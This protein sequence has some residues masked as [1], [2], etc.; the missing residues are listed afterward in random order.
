MW[1]RQTPRN[2]PRRW[3]STWE[4]QIAIQGESGP[5][6]I[7]NLAGRRAWVL[8]TS[9]GPP[10]KRCTT[11]FVRPSA[12]R[13]SVGLRPSAIHY[14]G[15]GG[16]PEKP[17]LEAGRRSRRDRSPFAI[18]GA[19]AHHFGTFRLRAILLASGLSLH[20]TSTNR[21]SSAARRVRQSRQRPSHAAS[22]LINKP[23]LPQSSSPV[24]REV[25]KL[26]LVKRQMYGRGKLDLL[27]AR[28]IGAA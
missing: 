19:R 6:R 17:P 26:K 22:L 7:R 9:G 16:A 25:T 20:R 18:Q 2:A 12:P 21:G 23:L 5:R 14:S 4:L 15:S 24:Q 11:V 1:R 28:V 27:Q 8:E 3:L 13:E 10:A